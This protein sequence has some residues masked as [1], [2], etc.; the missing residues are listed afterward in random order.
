[1]SVLRIVVR[2]GMTAEMADLLID[3]IREKTEWLES[4][5]SPMPGE[6]RQAFAHN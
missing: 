5:T 6:A 4:L 1:M 2:A 3:T